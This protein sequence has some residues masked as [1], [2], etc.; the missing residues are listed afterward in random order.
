[1]RFDDVWVLRSDA[2]GT[3]GE[4]HRVVSARVSFDPHA[5]LP[6]WV[7]FETHALLDYARAAESDGRPLG[8]DPI[9]ARLL[10]EAYIASRVARLL[11]MRARAGQSRGF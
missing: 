1:M 3:E 4:G 10:V 7:E 2:L 5:D 9:L 8:S 11:R 6:S